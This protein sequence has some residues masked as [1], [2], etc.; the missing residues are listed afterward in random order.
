MI[1]SVHH[2]SL[3]VHPGLGPGHVQAQPGASPSHG[4]Q[5]LHLETQCWWHPLSWPWLCAPGPPGGHRGCTRGRR[6][7]WWWRECGQVKLWLQPAQN[8]FF[9][10]SILIWSNPYT[11]FSPNPNCS[12]HQESI[13]CA[14]LPHSV[15]FFFCA[16]FPSP[17]L[18]C[19]FAS[20][21]SVL[22]FK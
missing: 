17:M 1:D 18:F 14:P 21:G 11:C 6:C 9:L 15:N 10:F 20:L 8:T 2:Y 16:V 3:L 22:D 4:G 5:Y 13:F 19:A 12:P 7:P